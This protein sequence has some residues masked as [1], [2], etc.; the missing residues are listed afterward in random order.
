[1]LLLPVGN[2][3]RF[4]KAASIVYS[5]WIYLD[6]LVFLLFPDGYYKTTTGHTGHVL[7]DDNALIFVM[8][9]G[10]IIVVCNSLYN[11]GKVSAWAWLT[12]LVSTFCITAVWAVSGLLTMFVFIGLLVYI[13][14]RRRLEPRLMLLGLILIIVIVLVGLSNPFI[15]NFIENTLEKILP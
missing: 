14:I 15:S 7:G 10:A 4:F 9:P 12:I 11:F 5:S 1:M 13:L 2:G 3:R 6:F 8:L